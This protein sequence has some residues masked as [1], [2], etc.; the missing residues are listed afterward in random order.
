MGPGVV[1]CGAACGLV[2]KEFFCGGKL[3][4]FVHKILCFRGLGEVVFVD[5]GSLK[6]G[7]PKDA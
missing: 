2:W 6:V 4:G 7:I 5:G 1:V 3:S